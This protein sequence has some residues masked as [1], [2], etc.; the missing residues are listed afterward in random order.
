[1]GNPVGILIVGVVLIG[2]M[3]G[4]ATAYSIGYYLG[5]RLANPIGRFLR[6]SPERM[7]K[8]RNA[9]VEKSRWTIVVGRFVPAVMLPLSLAAGTV[10][11]PLQ[12][13][14][15]GTGLAMVLWMVFFAGMGAVFDGAIDRAVET[16]KLPLILGIAAIAVVATGLGIVSW[17]L[18]RS[19]RVRAI[20]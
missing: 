9:I 13:F 19:A 2:F 20:I 1:L 10:R 15:T 7:E 8:A 14:Y 18:I 6:I 16:L 17:R 12:R 4:S 5:D 11:L 3:G